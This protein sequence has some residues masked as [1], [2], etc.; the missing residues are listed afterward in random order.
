LCFKNLAF[1]RGG[2]RFYAVSH[3]CP[4]GVECGGAK[5]K[6]GLAFITSSQRYACGYQGL[7]YRAGQE[8]Q[9]EDH[10]Q[11]CKPILVLS[12]RLHGV[13]FYFKSKGKS[14]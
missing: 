7:H 4:G 9:Q 3:G 11:Q 8:C 6:P 5:G 12:A 13:R 14:N 1:R 10:H 2:A